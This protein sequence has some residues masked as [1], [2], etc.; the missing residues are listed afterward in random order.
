M[1]A[2]K[3]R[4]DDIKPPQSLAWPMLI[5][6]LSFSLSMCSVPHV[7]KALFGTSLTMADGVLTAAVSVTSAVGG[8]GEPLT[9]LH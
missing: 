9:K 6:V 2:G 7:I 8:I 5:W 3:R 4:R 1:M